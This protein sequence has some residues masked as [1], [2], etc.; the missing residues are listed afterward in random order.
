MSPHKLWESPSYGILP[1]LKKAN[2]KYHIGIYEEVEE[3]QYLDE[4]Q[5]WKVIHQNNTE[6]LPEQ[7]SGDIHII[8]EKT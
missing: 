3:T 1:N 7:L 4:L 8:T 6:V 5:L 2:G